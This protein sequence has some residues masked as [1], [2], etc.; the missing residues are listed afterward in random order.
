MNDLYIWGIVCYC[1]GVCTVL[2]GFLAPKVGAWWRD[3]LWRHEFPTFMD[4]KMKENI[5]EFQHR[6]RMDRRR[7][8]YQT[9][10]K[11]DRMPPRDVV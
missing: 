1:A 3:Y 2:L 11:V 4:L 8:I 5:R 9:I 7:D 10:R 6:A